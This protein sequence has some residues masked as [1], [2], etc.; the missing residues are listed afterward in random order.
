LL[1]VQNAAYHTLG[2]I[3]LQGQKEPERRRYF[4]SPLEM[5]AGDD[6]VPVFVK[7]CAKIIEDKGGSLTPPSLPHT[8]TL[9]PTPSPPPP[10]YTLTCTHTTCTHTHTHT[11]HTYPAHTHSTPHTQLHICS[12][13]HTCAHYAHTHTKHTHTHTHT[14]TALK[15]ERIYRVSGKKEDCLALQERFDEGMY[16]VGRSP[17]LWHCQESFPS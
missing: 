13:T 16:P 12:C 6:G 3:T 4:G 9:L 14:H 7:M 2:T 8:L 1:T 10:L 11:L 15:S 17:F 5:V